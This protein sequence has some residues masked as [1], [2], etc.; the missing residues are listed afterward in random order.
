MATF[1]SKLLVY[2]RHIM[3]ISRFVDV[4]FMHTFRPERGQAVDKPWTNRG[5]T[6]LG[7]GTAYLERF[8]NKKSAAKLWIPPL[9][10]GNNL[11]FNLDTLDGIRIQ[12]HT[13]L[14]L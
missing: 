8:K 7:R 9:K 1:N 2:Q 14:R 6:C 10:E 5:T 11:G 3:K 12:T 13:I 4:Q